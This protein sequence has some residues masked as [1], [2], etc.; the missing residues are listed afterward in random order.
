M[1]SSSPNKRHH[2][3]LWALAFPMLAGC[4][5]SA[6][7]LPVYKP[8]PKSA[9]IDRSPPPRTALPAVKVVP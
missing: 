5:G 8:A 7:N 2:A 9:T 3:L 4:A 1:P 6:A